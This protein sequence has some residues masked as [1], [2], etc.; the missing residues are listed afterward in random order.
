MN[1]NGK[2][3]QGPPPQGPP[4]QSYHHNGNGNENNN[5]YSHGPVNGNGNGVNRPHQNQYPHGYPA[6]HQG[7]GTDQQLNEPTGTVAA[8]SAPLVAPLVGLPS[9]QAQA[10]LTYFE[11]CTQRTRTIAHYKRIEQIGEGTYGQVY[12]A[13]CLS[14]NR[15]VALKKIRLTS[16][17]TEGLPRT[18]IR[19]IKILKALKHENMVQMLEVVSSKGC[20]YLDEEDEHK[21]DKKRRLLTDEANN[22]KGEKESSKDKNNNNDTLTEREKYKG[23]L[24]LVLEYISHDLSGI[25]DMGIR[26]DPVQSKYIFRQLLSV[27][28]YMHEQRYVHRD[29]KSSNILIDQ[30]YKVKLADFGLARSID[31]G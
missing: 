3:P 13:K 8:S 11:K 12:K 31:D 21:E 26:F 17:A 10:P 19:E 25:L 22:I 15:I 9:Q 20:E 30:R 16:V 24:F 14:S 27:L 28:D 1:R 18:V 4:P 7:H 29:L 5:N 6:Y 2:G 23:N